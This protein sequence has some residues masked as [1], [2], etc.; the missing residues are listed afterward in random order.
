MQKQKRIKHCYEIRIIHLYTDIFY[1][2]TL[3]ILS[4][5][6]NDINIFYKLF[7][8]LNIYKTSIINTNCK[9]IFS[10]FIEIQLKFNEV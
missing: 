6:Y 5:Y 10:L 3:F 1:F 7:S 8:S 4:S 9:A 2:Y